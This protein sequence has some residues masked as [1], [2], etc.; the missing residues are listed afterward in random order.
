MHCLMI[1]CLIVFIASAV[2]L[3]SSYVVSPDSYRVTYTPGAIGTERYWAF[4]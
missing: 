3:F 2:V 4:E 1:N